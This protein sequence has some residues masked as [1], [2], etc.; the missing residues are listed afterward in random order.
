MAAKSLA[1]LTA[2]L[3][4]VALFKK[5]MEKHTI[6]PL[7][8]NRVW[9]ENI[10]HSPFFEHCSDDTSTPLGGAFLHSEVGCCGQKILHE[11]LTDYKRI[12]YTT[13]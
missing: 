6:S 3:Q 1:G 2:L 12:K 11:H 5:L 9:A 10:G 7:H 4:P 8:L 13:V